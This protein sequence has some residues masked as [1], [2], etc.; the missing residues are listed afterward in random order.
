MQLRRVFFGRVP[1]SPP[2]PPPP[3]LFFRFRGVASSLARVFAMRA[4]FLSACRR[5][6][7]IAAA[8]FC[9]VVF[10]SAFFV[11][12]CG[13]SRTGCT[14]ARLFSKCR[15]V[16]SHTVRTST[17]VRDDSVS[18]TSSCCAEPLGTAPSVGNQRGA[19][20]CGQDASSQNALIVMLLGACWLCGFW[21][22]GKPGVPLGLLFFDRS[23]FN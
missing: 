16:R 2:P 8:S 21:V 11:G 14:D 17:E 5:L 7:S 10:F 3:V 23:V 9:S 15:C 13:G 19:D 20:S 18:C 12:C 22:G 6:R 4:A 1:S